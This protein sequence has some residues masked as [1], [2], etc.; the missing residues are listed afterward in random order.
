M[1]RRK[2]NMQH[3]RWY[4]GTA[5]FGSSVGVGLFAEEAIVRAGIKQDD[6]SRKT[7]NMKTRKVVVNVAV[8]VAYAMMTSYICI[9][10]ELFTITRKFVSSMSYI[11]LTSS[12]K[13]RREFEV[14]RKTST[15]DAKMLL[16]FP[17]LIKSN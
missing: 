2:E 16:F 10:N 12:T 1:S 15:Q 17:R 4:F 7:V 9:F 3:Q 14:Q 11:C 5:K 13:Q 6:K 8:A